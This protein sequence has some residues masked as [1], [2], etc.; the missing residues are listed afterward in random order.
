[1]ICEFQD[2]ISGT[3]IGTAELRNGLYYFEEGSPSGKQAVGLNSRLDSLPIK[4]QITIWHQ[5]LRHPSFPY[6]KHL[7]PSLFEKCSPLEFQCDVCCFSKSN[8]SSYHSKPY[9]ASK[10]FYL[11]HS[12]VWGPCKVPTITNKRWFL[13]VL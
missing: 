7:F 5:R 11:I 2:R 10:P 4:E 6:L 1:M 3:M 13:L 8:K 9:R 12:D